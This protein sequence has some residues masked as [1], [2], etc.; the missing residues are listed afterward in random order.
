MSSDTTT[1]PTGVAST[2][3]E[4]RRVLRDAKVF[5]VSIVGGPGSGKTALIE[6]SLSHLTPH[7]RVGIIACDAGTRHEA[8]GLADRGVPIVKI[9]PAASG[10]LDAGAVA[11]AL[12]ALPL[13][14]IDLLLI[15]NAGSLTP[16]CD[17]DLGQTITATVFSVAGGDGQA[18]KHSDLVRNADVL[19]LNKTDL[20]PATPFD[21][22]SFHADVRRLNPQVPVFEVSALNGTGTEIWAQWLGKQVRKSKCL[23]SHWFG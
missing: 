2:G 10:H 15:E 9:R 19:I 22:A 13:R 23:E 6:R 17:G 4:V 20:L 12:D 11:G 14:G 21:L 1:R 3:E 18:D 5:A 7:H 16:A 8:A